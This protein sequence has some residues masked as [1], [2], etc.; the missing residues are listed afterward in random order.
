MIPLSADDLARLQ[1]QRWEEHPEYQGV[2]TTTREGLVGGRTVL[3]KRSDGRCVFLTEEN[4]CR[5]HELH[6]EA[7][8]PAVCRMFP[9]QVVPL[10]EHAVITPRRSCPTAAADEGPAIKEQLPELKRS[11]LFSTRRRNAPPIVRSLP[12]DWKS[13]S[14]AGAAL[15]RLICDE[16]IPM[17]R[18]LIHGL[19]FASLLDDAKFKKVDDEALNALIELLA[20]VAT[21]GAGEYFT[22]RQP[23]SAAAASLFRQAAAHYVRVH[24]GFQATNTWGERWRMMWTSLA[25]TRGRGE[26]PPVH[27]EFPAATFDE[28][29]R[30]L[31]ALDETVARP[32]NRFIETHAVSKQYALVGAGGRTLVE[33]FRLLALSFPIAMWLLRWAVGD[34]EPETKD[35]IDI[36]VALERGRGVPS[37][38]RSAG[39][40]GQSGQLPR[41]VAWYAR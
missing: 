19:Q 4:R 1:S 10:E 18:R 15:Q 17:V 12:G 7:A 38:A 37:I 33:N 34:R 20:G 6:G 36:V 26:V 11:G 2:K 39:A 28:L 3:A 41:L 29:E 24:P 35:M 13:F 22:D 40:M 23:A 8:K 27:P 31:G 14:A 21:E 30:P 5:I 9:L 16:R 32:L 25:F